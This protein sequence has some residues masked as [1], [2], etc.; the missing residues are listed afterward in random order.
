MRCVAERYTSR[1][2]G[3]GIGMSGELT[4]LAM[5]T[6]TVELELRDMDTSE[7]E[8]RYSDGNSVL[9]SAGSSEYHA[10]LSPVGLG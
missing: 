6:D 5:D 2:G 9:M 7:V 4:R 10:S 3:V 1:K 8:A